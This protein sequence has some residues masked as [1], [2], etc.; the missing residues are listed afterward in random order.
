MK[1]TG[2]L[3][4]FGVL[5]LVVAACSPVSKI[6]TDVLEP[7][8]MSFPEEVYSVGFLL[9]EPRMVVNTRTN[10]RPDDVDGRQQFWT[11]LMDVAMNSPRFNPRSLYLVEP[12]GDTIPSDTLSWQALEHWTDSLDLDALAVL[13]QFRLSDSLRRKLVFDYGTSNYYFIYKVNAR[14]HWRIYDPRNRMMVH[15]QKYDEEFVWESAAPE[16]RQ[17]LRDLVGLDR[18][19][20][21]SSYWSGYD[22][23]QI[24]FPYWVSETRSYYSRGSRNFR[25]ARDYVR[26]NRWQDAIDLW[27]KSFKRSND[28]LAHRAAYNIAFALEMLGKV[29]KAIDW[30]NRAQEIQ[31]RKKTREYLDILEQR[32]EKLNQ[33]DEQM[34]I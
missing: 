24:L 21:L 34:P 4:L 12:T 3:G 16:E 20:R 9:G 11:G 22:I 7:A 25:D 1:R 29:D 26:E 13:H 17:A 30:L 5:L 8:G 23:G 27:K 32:R 18:A 19:Y 10:D 2:I 14:I 15:E 6:N 33:L 28:E 31:Y